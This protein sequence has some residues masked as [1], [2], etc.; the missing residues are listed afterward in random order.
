MSIRII[1]RQSDEGAAM[2]VGGPVQTSHKT[3][4]V[5]LPELEQ[6]LRAEGQPTYIRRE[7]IGVELLTLPP[8]VEGDERGRG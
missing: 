5:D 7:L 2:H 1:V 6:F 3:F 8:V 4:D